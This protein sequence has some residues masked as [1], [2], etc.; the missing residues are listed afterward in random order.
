MTKEKNCKKCRKSIK[1]SFD[2]CPYCGKAT[3]DEKD[4][5][6]LGKD[7]FSE[8]VQQPAPFSGG[9]LNN[10]IGSAMKMMEQEMQK[11]MR[12]MKTVRPKT[13]LQLYVNGKK[14]NLEPQ[15]PQPCR[16]LR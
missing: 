11:N 9:F 5:G 8:K 12:D 4:W 16:S 7:D 2:F 1:K 3:Y 13:K 6:M 15:S 10:I 14:I